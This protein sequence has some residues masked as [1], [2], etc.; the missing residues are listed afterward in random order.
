MN[1]SL[2][3]RKSF[4]ALSLGVLTTTFV[5]CQKEQTDLSNSELTQAQQKDFNV[6]P[7]GLESPAL[8]GIAANYDKNADGVLNTAPRVL[9]NGGILGH[10]NSN[11]FAPYVNA[12][13]NLMVDGWQLL[14]QMGYAASI[15]GNRLFAQRTGRTNGAISMSFTAG[16][17]IAVIGGSN[18]TMPS[19]AVQGAN[20]RIVVPARFLAGQAGAAARGNNPANI[21]YDADTQSLQIYDYE[22]CDQGIYFYGSQAGNTDAIGCQKFVPGQANRFFD[23]NKPTIIYTHGWQPNGVINRTREDFTFIADP[24]SG[25]VVNVHNKW[26]NDGWNVAIYHWVQLADDKAPS[27]TYPRPYDEECKIYD[28]NNRKVGMRWK[29]TD[30]TYV[31]SSVFNQS[32]HQLY[33]GEL[34]KLFGV[35]NGSVELRLMGNSLGGNLTM[36]TCYE[37][38]R[39]GNRLPARVTLIDPYWTPVTNADATLP[40]RGVTNTSYDVGAEAGRILRS[41][42]RGVEYIRTSILGVDGAN[43]YLAEVSCFTHFGVDYTWNPAEKHTAPVKQYLWSRSFAAPTLTNVNALG[44]ANANVPTSRILEMANTS[45]FGRRHWNHVQGRGTRTPSDDR[46]EQRN[47]VW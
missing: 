7:S 19:P 5:S 20:G 46:F 23:P 15:S 42:N 32:V 30:G 35:L 43:S 47:G 8:Y 21:D 28:A 12:Q 25:S 3:S 4:W 41:N 2:F 33:A 18:V 17:N 38:N 13:G 40:F 11:Y 29:K 22:F 34:R 24:A 1:H 14:T 36:A 31:T 27:A 44:G 45:G 37:L 26:I 16:S 9:V 39:T 6:F 10:G